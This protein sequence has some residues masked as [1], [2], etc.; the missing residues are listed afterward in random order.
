[1]GIEDIRA[2]DN[3]TLGLIFD[4]DALR[5]Q[6]KMQ[7]EVRRHLERRLVVA[8]L[9]DAINYADEIVRLERKIEYWQSVARHYQDIIN[10][11]PPK[12]KIE[13]VLE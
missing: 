2:S 7:Q 3:D 5:R 1:M 12:N 10:D 11:C 4:N 13:A 8:G 9:G 6:I